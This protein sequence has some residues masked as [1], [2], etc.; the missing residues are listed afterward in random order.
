MV[1]SAKEFRQWKTP[2]A[3]PIILPDL[4]HRGSWGILF[5]DQETYKSWAV[6]DLA[7]EVAK[8]GKWLGHW[9]VR[10]HSV[11]IINTEIPAPLYQQ[12]WFTMTALKLSE[13]SNLYV[14]NNMSLKL[15]NMA[16]KHKLEEYCQAAVPGLIIIDNLYR[17]FTGD[18]NSGNNVNMFLDT[19]NNIREKHNV[20]ILFVHH[21]RKVDYDIR[22]NTVIRRGVQDI[23]GSK[24]LANNA[25]LIF[26]T[27]K[28]IDPSNGE[29]YVELYREKASFSTRPAS[30]MLTTFRIG[31]QVPTFTKI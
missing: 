25:S 19:I 17:T 20:S 29:I 1:L 5:G 12:R 11:L 28:K 31:D 23:S 18:M 9:D 3:E 13:P 10:K 21:S 7:W 16:G 27:R 24:Y 4:L 8:G 6:M 26:E 14:V 30:D 2:P 15:D 22:T